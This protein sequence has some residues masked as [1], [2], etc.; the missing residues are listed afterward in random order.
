MVNHFLTSVLVVVLA[1]SA[2]QAQSSK[3]EVAVKQEL[4]CE[5]LIPTEAPLVD[6]YVNGGLLIKNVSE[7]AI[8][9]CILVAG[10]RGVGKGSYSE[11][12]CPDCWKS[13]SPRPE[14]F[15]KSIVV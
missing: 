8:K 10:F 13:D 3:A 14:D 1:A 6:G 12:F 4:T 2:G 5:I 9:I 15:A 11:V 7:Q